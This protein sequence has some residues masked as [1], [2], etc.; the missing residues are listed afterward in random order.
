MAKFDDDRIV[1]IRC[2]S[3]NRLRPYP[4]NYED[5]HCGCGGLA[6]ISSWPH[7]DE[8]ALALK[9]YSRQIEERNLWR[10]LF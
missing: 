8:E 10:R 9:I 1:P 7:P 3:C 6:F 4:H 5:A 2:T